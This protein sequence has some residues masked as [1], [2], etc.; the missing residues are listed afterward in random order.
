[1]NK[2]EYLRTKSHR[3]KLYNLDKV[4]ENDKI[5]YS[6]TRDGEFTPQTKN[7]LTPFSVTSDGSGHN[8]SFDTIGGQINVHLDDEDISALHELLKFFAR[9]NGLDGLYVQREPKVLPT[10]TDSTY[11][12]DD[13]HFF[14]PYFMS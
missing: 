5:K 13:Y 2:R 6:I 8:L 7:L 1:V 10:N 4:G 3:N 14:S 9:E 11:D 12:V